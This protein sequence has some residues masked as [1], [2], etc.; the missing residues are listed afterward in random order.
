MSHS[1]KMRQLVFGAASAITMLLATAHD[2][3]ATFVLGTGN[4]GGLGDNVIINACT[5]NTLGPAATVQGCFNT[6]HTTLIDVNRSGGGNLVANGGQARFDAAV[7]N[8]DNFSINFADPSLGFSGIVFNINSLNGSPS[9]VAFT[10]NAFDK[11]GNA[12]VAQVFNGVLGNGNNFFNLTS[13]D[14]EVATKVSVLSSLANIEDIRQIRIAEEDLPP[15]CPTGQTC[16]GGGPGIPEPA[17]LF[18]F[19]SAMLGYGAVRR[20]KR[21]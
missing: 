9:T 4:V 20:R 7:T 12:E 16:G 6:S 3:N 17:T 1:K 19:G 8:T 2:A 15:P 10:V 21:K 13:A 14:G 5:G 11:F 18:L